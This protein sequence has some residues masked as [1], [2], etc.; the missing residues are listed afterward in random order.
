M[1]TLFQIETD[2]HFHSLMI[3]EHLRPRWLICHVENAGFHAFLIVVTSAASNVFFLLHNDQ[4]IKLV[5]V[6]SV[7]TVCVCVLLNQRVRWDYRV[8][9]L[10]HICF[11]EESH[12]MAPVY[13]II[14][15]VPFPS[16]FPTL[17]TLQSVFQQYSFCEVAL[18]CG[19]L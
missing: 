5:Y 6:L 8:S 17:F 9:Q 11:S 13:N 14:Q 7:N 19:H 1:Q 3:Y 18:M 4:R 10:E 2:C 12:N 16:V 15:S